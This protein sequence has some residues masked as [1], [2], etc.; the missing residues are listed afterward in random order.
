L[1]TVT[2]P[3][4]GLPPC[5]SE[6]LSVVGETERTALG[7]ET[8]MVTGTEVLVPPPVIVTLPVKVPVDDRF[9]TLIDTGTDPGVVPV[10]LADAVLEDAPI[11]SQ[12]PVLEADAVK[13]A[14]A[15]V[16][17]TEMLCPAGWLEDP[18]V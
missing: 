12:L 7:G 8:V 13:L 14:P 9:A 6:K 18:C 10:T 15:G 2:C 3:L 17:D 4:A 11:E 5:T 16:L 1:D